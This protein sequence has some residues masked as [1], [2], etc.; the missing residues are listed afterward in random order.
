VVAAVIERDGHWLVGR[1]P[2]HKRHG[3]LWEFPG[4][5]VDLGEDMAE[6]TRRELA[7]ELALEV[8]HVG[9][10]LTTYHDDD[11][12]F[13]IEFLHVQVTGT[14]QALEHS[15]VG[16]YT[17]EQ[18]RIMPLAPA[19]ASCVAWLSRRDRAGSA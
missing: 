13:L 18:L 3:G 19:D 6:A 12:P 9:D 7:E 15:E 4:G 10:R 14:P 11:S 2:D 16:W 17:L 8:T 5:K 1:R